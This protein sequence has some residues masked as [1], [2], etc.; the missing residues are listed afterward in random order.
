VSGN[1]DEP[2]AIVLQNLEPAVP[3][4]VFQRP[5]VVIAFGVFRKE[6]P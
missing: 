4:R 3:G 5:R 1:R 2:V 6:T